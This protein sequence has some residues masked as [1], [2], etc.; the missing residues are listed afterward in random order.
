M[1]ADTTG[2]ARSKILHLLKTRGPQTAAALGEALGVTAM[3]VRHHLYALSEENLV[4]F[5]D[6]N[7]GV[8]RP[9]RYW[10]LTEHGATAGFTDA[11]AELAAS[12]I[13]AAQR[14]FGDEGLD[15]L[16]ADRKQQ[17]FERYRAR[18]D[19]L[20]RAP[21]SLAESVQRLADLRTADGYM[22]EVEIADDGAILLIEN[23][24]PI[25]VAARACARL[26]ASELD[27]FEAL[28][29]RD[30]EIQRREHM[31]DGSRRCL[32]RISPRGRVGKR[33]TGET[34]SSAKPATREQP[35]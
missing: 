2:S 32:Y 24:C 8:G 31:F 3:A 34:A 7:Q 14:V 25:C 35:S 18:L 11:H 1:D 28:I 16:V 22:A 23:H 19:E 29:G 26:C 20:G 27:L 4:D 12:M 10:R 5:A 17:T 21:R 30:A 15:K 9:A 13:A 33:A 6:E